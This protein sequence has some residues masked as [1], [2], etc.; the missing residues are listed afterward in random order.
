LARTSNPAG[1][2]FTGCFT[3]RPTISC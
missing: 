3:S 2:V 1:P